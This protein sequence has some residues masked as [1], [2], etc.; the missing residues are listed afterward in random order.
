VSTADRPTSLA[1]EAP[2]TGELEGRVALVTG[3]AGPGIGQA[4]ALLLARRGASVVVTDR[5]ER[6]AHEVAAACAAA[7]ERFD[8]VDVLVNNAGMSIAAPITATTTE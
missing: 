2:G 1:G 5:S 6:R 3:A 4:R 7:L 8:R